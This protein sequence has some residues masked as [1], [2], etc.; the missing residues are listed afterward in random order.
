MVARA[1]V[2]GDAGAVGADHDRAPV[3][4]DV[5]VLLVEAPREERRVDRDD[6][7]EPAERHPGGGGHRVLLGDADVDEAARGSGPRRASSPVGPGIAAVIADDPRRSPAARSRSALRERLGVARARVER[8]PTASAAP[9]AERPGAATVRLGLQVVEA[10]DLVRLGRAVALAL[11][12]E[13]VEHDR[14]RVA[15][16]PCA[17][18]CS[19]AADVVAVDRTGVADA[20]RLEEHVRLD[21]LA[22]RRGERCGATGPASW[23][24]P[25]ISLERPGRRVAR[26]AP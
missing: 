3:Q 4:A 20:E 19:T 26:T 14:A 21:E 22:E 18:A 2:A 6:G 8:G 7:A 24:T 15:W 11:A 9:V 25:G 1:V 12:G 10:L 5:E 23:P 17:S 16:R 13:H